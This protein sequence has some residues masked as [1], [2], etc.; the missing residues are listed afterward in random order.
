MGFLVALL[1]DIKFQLG[2]HSGREPVCFEPLDL[3]LENASRG[4]RNL[5][6]GDLIDGVAED[7]RGSFQP[8]NCAQGRPVGDR[9]VVAIPGFP[10][11]VAEPLGR[12]ELHV[13]GEQVGAEMG[14]MIETV[15]DEECAG[16][17]LAD[18]P[19]LHVADGRDH[20][21]DFAGPDPGFKFLHADLAALHGVLPDCR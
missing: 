18:E 21:V 4:D 7:Q 10:V 13:G 5:F 20:G 17:A 19:P 16:H 15:I 14:A 12:G 3:V 1:Q 9:E 8:R 2:G 11:H 6:A